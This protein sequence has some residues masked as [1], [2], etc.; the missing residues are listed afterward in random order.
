MRPPLHPQKERNPNMT[1]HTLLV[2][3][4]KPLG[5]GKLYLRL[6]HGRKNPD[7]D[8]DDWGFNGPVFGPLSAVVMTYLTTIRLHGIRLCDEVWLETTR[9]MVQWQ[10]DYYGDFELFVAGP[11]ST[12]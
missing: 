1:E 2:P 4:G 5:K 8:M 7:Q 6:Y 3:A 10:G 12:A 9:D 11:K